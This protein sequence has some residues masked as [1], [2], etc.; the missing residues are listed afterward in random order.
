MVGKFCGIFAHLVPLPS[1]CSSDLGLEQMAAQF[2]D[3]PFE[4]EA[5]EQTLLANCYVHLFKFV[6]GI[7]K[8]M[9]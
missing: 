8:G 5:A 6:W 1:Q 3:H 4:P 9:I 7:S 2:L